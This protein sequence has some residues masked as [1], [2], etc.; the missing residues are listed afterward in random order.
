MVMD[1]YNF[2]NAERKRRILMTTRRGLSLLST[3]LLL[4]RLGAGSIHAE[5][6]VISATVGDDPSGAPKAACARGCTGDA[7]VCNVYPFPQR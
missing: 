6:D 7:D 3:T 5:F 2:S 4:G 1:C